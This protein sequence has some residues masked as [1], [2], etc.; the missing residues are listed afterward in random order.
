MENQQTEVVKETDYLGVTLESSGGLSKQKATQKVKGIQALVVSDKCLTR[1]PDMG[2]KFL[3]N[4]YEMVCESRMIYGVEKRG[5]EEGWKEIDKIH[6]R[7]YK[8]NLGIP[9]FAANGVAELELGIDSRRGK[10]M[11]IL[12]KYW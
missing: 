3:E 8:K 6:E 12:V 9:R 7:M 1:T 10:V 11:S 4:V 2:V 5:V